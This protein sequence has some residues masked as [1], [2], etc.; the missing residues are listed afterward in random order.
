MWRGFA[1]DAI[2]TVIPSSPP[3]AVVPVT[4]PPHRKQIHRRHTPKHG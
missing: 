2:A 1:N 4:P 3:P